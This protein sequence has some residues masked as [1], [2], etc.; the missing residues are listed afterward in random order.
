[1]AHLHTFISRAA[2]VAMACLPALAL[3]QE[4]PDAVAAFSPKDTLICPASADIVDPEFQPGG[5]LMTFTNSLGELRVTTMPAIGKLS[6]AG[7]A[8][9]VIDTNVITKMPGVPF[10]Q[11]PEWARSQAGTE[12]VYTKANADGS[13]SM[14]RAWQNGGTWT[15][16]MMTNGNSRGVP[17]AS[18]DAS[19]PQYRVKYLRRLSSGQHVPMWRENELPDTETAWPAQGNE[20]TAGVPRWVPGRRALT[21]VSTDAGG[22]AQA[23]LYWLD[24]RQVEVLTSDPS[25][26]DEMWMWSAPEFGN[27]YVFAAIVDGCCIKIYR[28]IGGVWTVINSLDA[29][30][31]ANQP[32]IFSPEP[33]VH[34]GKSYIA[35]QVGT[36]K[37]S[38]SSIWFA[39]IDPAKP[40]VR[41]VSDP[42]TQAIRYE[43][44]WFV[45]STGPVIFFSQ[46]AGDKSSFRRAA[47]GLR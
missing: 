42:S 18:T 40:L 24:T 11:R 33:F 15:T 31:F 12:I 45:T 16:A 20:N 14:W 21:T 44:E 9:T 36:T 41:Q 34:K 30:V 6:A 32:A 26:K 37:S 2:A 27:E 1:M 35:M 10:G 23:A 13:S 3:S 22:Y 39:A 17:M 8:G 25:N 19:D 47:T 7:C 4:G 28:Q 43:P 38:M 29:P 5:N 46:F